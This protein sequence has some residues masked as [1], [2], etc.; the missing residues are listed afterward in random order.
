MGMKLPERLHGPLIIASSILISGVMI[1]LGLL[2]L[3]NSLPYIPD[4]IN[5]D[6]DGSIRAEVSGYIDTD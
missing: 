6:I 2:H 4:R 3:A 5:A 1:F